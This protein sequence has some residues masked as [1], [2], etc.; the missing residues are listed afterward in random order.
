MTLNIQQRNEDHPD[1]VGFYMHVFTGVKF[2]PCDPRV[3]EIDIR[4]IAHGLSN[5][6]RF[7]GQS[8]RFLSTAEHSLLCSVYGPNGAIGDKDTALERLMHDAAEAYIGDIIRPIKYL[9]EFGR[10]Y[11]EL[12]RKLEDVIAERFGLVYPWEPHVKEADEAI[13]TLEMHHNIA[14]EDKGTLHDGSK[15]PTDFHLQYM[16]PEEAEEMF[17]EVFHELWEHRQNL[18][19][20]A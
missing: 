16:A 14:A 7:N 19:R 17:L 5:Q 1:R 10:T 4:D 8:K 6:C 3:E 11:L 20:A 2:W 15:M 12:E 9:D 18:G 13:V